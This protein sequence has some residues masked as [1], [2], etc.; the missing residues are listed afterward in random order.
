M[1][2]G[3]GDAT[4]KEQASLWIIQHRE[5]GSFGMK[6]LGLNTS[7]VLMDSHPGNSVYSTPQIR[8]HPIFIR[9]GE[10]DKNHIYAQPVLAIRHQHFQFTNTRL[11]ARTMRMSKHD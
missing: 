6:T 4:R 2:A 9:A 7:I 3:H 11:G 5:A 8:F 1:T 10:S